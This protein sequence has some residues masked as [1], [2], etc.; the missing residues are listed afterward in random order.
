MLIRFYLKVDSWSYWIYIYNVNYC[1]S[2]LSHWIRKYFIFVTLTQYA[3]QYTYYIYRLCI[4]TLH[5]YQPTPPPLWIAT[6]LA[7]RNDPPITFC[8]AMSAQNILP[9]L[10]LA[11]SLN[12]LEGH[13]DIPIFSILLQ[14]VTYQCLPR[15]GDP[16][17]IPLVPSRGV[18]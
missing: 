12:G 1:R 6:Q 9:S 14:S 4:E 11:V 2:L 3:R 17:S 5:T 13:W 16:Y 10:I 15:H 8:I 7:P 18:Q